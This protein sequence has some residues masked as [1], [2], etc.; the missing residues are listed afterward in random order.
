M[1]D[2]GDGYG[3]RLDQEA[4]EALGGVASP[5]INITG[6]TIDP[7]SG[8]I[9]LFNMVGVNGPTTWGVVGRDGTG[10]FSISYPIAIGAGARPGQHTVQHDQLMVAQYDGHLQLHER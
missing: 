6:S 3:D 5:A 7:K 9:A 1:N 4:A 8:N 10:I 2:N